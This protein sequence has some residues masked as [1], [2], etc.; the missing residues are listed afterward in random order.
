MCEKLVDYDI[1]KLVRQCWEGCWARCARD[2]AVHP[3]SVRRTLKRPVNTAG[4]QT[5][6]ACAAIH[7][8]LAPRT[9]AAPRSAALPWYQVNYFRAGGL[10]IPGMIGNPTDS[11][12]CIAVDRAAFYFSLRFAVQT[13]SRFP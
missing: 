3:S 13:L 7:A 2:G 10:E 6:R 11:V 12:A 4:S 1:G 8:A 5:P 9:K